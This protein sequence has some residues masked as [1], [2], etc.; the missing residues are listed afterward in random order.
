MSSANEGM[1]PERSCKRGQ[2]ARDVT[3]FPSSSSLANGYIG[4]CICFP[5]SQ[6]SVGSGA[7]KNWYE[8]NHDKPGKHDFCNLVSRSQTTNFQNVVDVGPLSTS[9]LSVT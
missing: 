8:N 5:R 1:V 6:E 7:W 4:I 3:L 2:M 9:I